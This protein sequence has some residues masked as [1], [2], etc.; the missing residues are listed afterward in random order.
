MQ[1]RNVGYAATFNARPVFAVLTG[2]GG[3]FV[4]PLSDDPRS[5]E[6]GGT[7]AINAAIPLAPA[8]PP[9]AYR[10]SLWLPDQALSIRDDPRFAVRFANTGVWDAATGENQLTTITVA[11]AHSGP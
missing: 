5:W 9:G 8:M 6:A 11:P 4:T 10:L 3:R 7:Y 2:Q 1:L